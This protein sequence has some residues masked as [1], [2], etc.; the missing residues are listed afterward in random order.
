MTEE[1]HICQNYC[2]NVGTNFLSNIWFSAAEW[3]K[4]LDQLQPKQWD[5]T[6]VPF[7][8]PNPLQLI[9]FIFLD[10]QKHWDIEFSKFR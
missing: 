6:M 3:V 8:N 10:F 1:Q 4:H 9:T 2:N 7:S 5:H